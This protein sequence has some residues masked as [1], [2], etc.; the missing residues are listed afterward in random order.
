[1]SRSRKKYPITKDYS[2]GSTK[3]YK[4]FASKSVRNYKGELSD[5]KEYRKLFNSYNIHDYT[6]HEWNPLNEWYKLLKRK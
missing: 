2:R 4:R 6:Y 3:E 5:G 1:M